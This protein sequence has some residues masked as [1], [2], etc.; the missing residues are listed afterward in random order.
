MRAT[1]Q[2]H[3][4]ERPLSPQGPQSV[5]FFPYTYTCLYFPISC[6]PLPSCILLMIPWLWP[7][8]R[9]SFLFLRG[10]DCS[11]RVLLPLPVML[12]GM[13]SLAG[14]SGTVAIPEGPA[15][16]DKDVSCLVLRL[17]PILGW[18]AGEANMGCPTQQGSQ[19]C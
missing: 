8:L 1:A 10:Q 17:P 16:Q 11:L 9:S 14:L 2:F 12:L 5:I 15:P 18:I 13:S 19:G 7:N 4:H 3:V 6:Q